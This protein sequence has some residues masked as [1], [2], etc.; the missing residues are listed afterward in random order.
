MVKIV[1]IIWAASLTFLPAMDYKKLSDFLA[2]GLVA[3]AYGSAVLRN[4]VQGEKAFIYSFGAN[5]ASTMGLKYIIDKKRPD[6]GHYG[7]PSGHTSIAFQSASFVH[8]RYGL[9][10]AAPMYLGAILVG[11]SRIRAHRHD[12]TD[13]IAGAI[14]GTLWGYTMTKKYTN[15]SIRPGTRK[16]LLGA[17]FQKNW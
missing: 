14:L 3:S 5:M 13:V 6:G 7:F 16:G 4:D 2:V 1:F 11:Y 10:Y 17:T 15:A 9:G 8:R 12:A